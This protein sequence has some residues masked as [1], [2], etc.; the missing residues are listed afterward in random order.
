[1]QHCFKAAFAILDPIS[2]RGRKMED[3]RKVRD[4][5]LNDPPVASQDWK[6]RKRR[7]RLGGNKISRHLVQLP[8][9]LRRIWPH[10]RTF[11]A[12]ESDGRVNASCCSPRLLERLARKRMIPP[13]LHKYR[14]SLRQWFYQSLDYVTTVRNS[15]CRACSIRSTRLANSNPGSTWPRS[16]NRAFARDRPTVRADQAWPDRARLISCG[17]TL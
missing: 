11:S 16:L 1:M 8:P 3:K 13:V 14:C 12:K 2:R 17:L 15:I 7:R 5:T 9:R 6:R 4:S 10:N